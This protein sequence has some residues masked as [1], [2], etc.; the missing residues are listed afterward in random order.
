MCLTFWGGQGFEGI[1]LCVSAKLESPKKWCRW[2]VAGYEQTIQWHNL[3]QIN[4][5]NMLISFS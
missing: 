5:A 4:L 3:L 2:T 1:W